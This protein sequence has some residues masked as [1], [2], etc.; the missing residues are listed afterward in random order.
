MSH[1][2]F[3]LDHG[4]GH[5]VLF[6]LAHGSLQWPERRWRYLHGSQE[7]GKHRPRLLPEKPLHRRGAVSPGEAKVVNGRQARA[8]SRMVEPAQ[9]MVPEREVSVASFYI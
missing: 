9:L 3:G 1:R 7:R 4:V 6:G 5:P 2:N 8:L